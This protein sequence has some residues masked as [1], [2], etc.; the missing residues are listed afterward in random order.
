MERGTRHHIESTFLKDRSNAPHEHS[1]LPWE[2]LLFEGGV[3]E[4]NRRLLACARL[5]LRFLSRNLS[6]SRPWAPA[7]RYRAP[8]RVLAA[9]PPLPE[10]GLGG[11]LRH[12]F[13]RDLARAE[14]AKNLSRS[15]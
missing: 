13:T 6:E 9:K 12:F 5:G 11:R 15:G 7:L 8:S 3:W 10:G 14:L 2:P 1:P 4:R